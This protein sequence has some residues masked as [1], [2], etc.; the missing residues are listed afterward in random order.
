MD[1][2]RT[3]VLDPHGRD[4]PAEVARLRALGAVVPVELPGG[5][6]AWAVTRHEL[7][8]S[9]MLDPRVSRDARR[10]W[11][12]YEK[13]GSEPGWGWIYSWTGIVNMLSSYGPDHTRLR[14]LVAPSFTRHRTETM[15]PRVRRITAALLDALEEVPEGQVVDLRA[16]FAHPLPMR[17]ICDL[18]GVPDRMRAAVA[19]LIESIMDTT[20]GPEQAANVFEQIVT[21]LP[22]LIAEKTR[23][24][25]DDLTTEL[26]TARD[27]GD[28][29]SEE[30]LIHTLLLVIGAGFE[31]T[32]NLIGNAV[33]ALLRHPEQ[34]KRVLAGQLEWEQVVQE[35]LR[36]APSI[37][38]VPLR[39]AVTDITLAEGTTIRAGEAILT[40]I[41]AAGHDPERFGPDAHLFDASRNAD[42]HLAL[43]I[44]VHRCVGAPLA[45]ME[46]LT[47][48]PAL[49]ERF[50]GI[51]LAVDDDALEQ[52]PSLIAQGW[53]ELPV[54]LTPAPP[55]PRS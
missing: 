5:I 25:G 48:L 6:P 1:N 17:M 46:A 7:L 49:F 28:R 29:L 45:R 24:P 35:T 44:G 9:L 53:R 36:W 14:K 40:T 27:Q 37:A 21:V 55:A 4:I 42:G 19:R 12:L 23:E 52:V 26:I 51:S 30:E 54:R 10:H 3:V 50:P 39:Y 16:E 2:R 20:G 32:V 41:A 13:A 47:A 43:G 33:H 31:T 34:L 22:E 38:N 11:A 15:L 8:K 18:F